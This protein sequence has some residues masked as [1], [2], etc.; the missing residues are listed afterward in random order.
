MALLF[1]A[2]FFINPR[3]TF[4]EKSA[5]SADHD[6]ACVSLPFPLPTPHPRVCETRYRISRGIKDRDSP[7]GAASR[8]HGGVTHLGRPGTRLFTPAVG[9]G[10]CFI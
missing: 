7:R 9:G 6:A 3:S 10:G 4:P 1:P 2:F 8:I 5:A